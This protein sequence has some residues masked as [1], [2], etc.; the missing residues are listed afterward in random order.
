M[1]DRVVLITGATGV[2]GRVVATA[3]AK[4]EAR[5]VLAGRR[6]TALAEMRDQLGLPSDRTFPIAADL[7][8]ADEVERLIETVAERWYGV[9]ILLNTVGGWRGGQRVADSRIEEWD[10][11]LDLNLRSAYL[12]NRAVLPYMIGRGWGRIVNVASKAA[13]VPGARQVAYN[14]AKAGVVSLTQSIAADY[15]R[16]G[17]CANA[18]LPSVIDTPSNR[19]QM[20]DADTTRWVAPEE[21]AK[22]MLFLCSDAG[23]AING[24]SI[25]V[26][27]RV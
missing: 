17:V 6:E 12:V 5:F 21:L 13:E 23:S 27:G 25:P 4:T 11:I 20:P 10:A 3:F 24:V 1:R 14:V 15:R 2:L 26:Y 22:L 8:N 7:A 9:D 16:R 18:L 19:E